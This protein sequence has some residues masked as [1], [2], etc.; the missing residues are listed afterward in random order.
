[1]SA[2]NAAATLAALAADEAATGG[3]STVPVEPLRRMAGPEEVKETEEAREDEDGAPRCVA[4]GAALLSVP[5][6]VAG[7]EL[8]EADDAAKLR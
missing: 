8:A 6:G 3:A 4:P 7:T 1:M 5:H 2:A